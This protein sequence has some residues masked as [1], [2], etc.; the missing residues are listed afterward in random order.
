MHG[1]DFYTDPDTGKRWGIELSTGEV[2]EAVTIEAVAGTIYYTPEQQRDI[3]R[4][5]Q[6]MLERLER[7]ENA[8]LQREAHRKLG[9]SFYFIPTSERFDGL[10][11]ATVTRLI[12]LNT[13]LALDNHKL[14]LT[15]RSALRKNDLQDVLGVSKSTVNRF[16]DEVTP[17]YIQVTDSGLLVNKDVFMRGKIHNPQHEQLMKFYCAGVQTLYKAV[18]TNMHARLGNLFKLLPFVNIEWNLL[19]RPECVMEKDLNK[20]ELLSMADFCGL[21]RF[22]VAHLNDLVSSYKEIVFDVDGR[23]ELFCAM[24]YDGVHTGT[25]KIC[26]NPHILYSGTCP[27]NV[28]GFS[29]LCR[30]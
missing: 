22:D 21:I 20:I 25:A 6:A 26:I 17:Q 27:D 24:T 12:Y 30:V 19:C 10:S 15:Q 8:R 13:F 29:A 23:K 28:K 3:E 5:K 16:V 9:N 1:Y 2:R 18:E 14:M 11:P 4:R 7:E